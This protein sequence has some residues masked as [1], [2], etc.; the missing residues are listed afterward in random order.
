MSS[1]RSL[2]ESRKVIV[3][4][5][6]GG[7]G[8]TTTAASIAFA[9]ARTGRRVLVLTIDPSKRLAEALGVSPNL[10][11]PVPVCEKTARDA[12]IEASGALEAWML[13]PS[14]IAEQAVR[15]LARSPEELARI[16][17]NRLYQGISQMLA[18][19][20]EYTAMKAL[21]RFVTEGRYD[22]I[23]LD[24]PPSRH[25]LD[26]LESP[27][28]VAE[29][30]EGRVFKLFLPSG[31]EGSGGGILKRA[32]SSL[33]QQIL[34]AVFGAEFAG[35]IVLFFGSFGGMLRALNQDLS[36][37][38]ERLRDPH[39]AAFLLVTSS[40][41]AALE[42][43]FFF[44]RRTAEL[45]L[46]FRGFLLNR[47]WACELDRPMPLDA[48]AAGAVSG[49]LSDE[50]HIALGKLQA[51]AL[52]ERERAESDRALLESLRS[53]AGQEAFA[54]AL[55]WLPRKEEGTEMLVSLAQS[56]MSFG[57]K[58]QPASGT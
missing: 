56:L 1:I 5:G 38:R 32:A 9:A 10:P 25:A 44:Q 24:T 12:G 13:D 46:P 58:P 42:E 17:G 28:R 22:L 15:K 16:L 33:V 49:S 3:C 26:F 6:A 43:A 45:G 55:P 27:G 31:A 8:K 41:D 11:A 23:V 7:V 47:T 30:L 52:T 4:C 36:T 57:G 35:D 39:F 50:Q 40:G 14:I 29:F 37:V 51:L 19:M 34:S 20:Q 48:S 18:G 53:R 21:H 54:E 2:I